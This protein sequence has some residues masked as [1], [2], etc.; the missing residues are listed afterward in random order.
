MSEVKD[1]NLHLHWPK[2][3]VRQGN[4]PMCYIQASLKADEGDS[5]KKMTCYEGLDLSE[6]L[7]LSLLS[8]SKCLHNSQ[9]A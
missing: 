3:E 5:R 7:Y 8:S 9:Y 6:H 1:G 4:P 2:D